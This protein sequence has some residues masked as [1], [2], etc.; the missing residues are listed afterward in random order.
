M[1]RTGANSYLQWDFENPALSYGTPFDTPDWKKFGLQQKITGFSINNTKK[2]LAEM[3][4]IEPTDYAYGKQVGSLSVDFVLS[5][6]WIFGMLFGIPVSNNSVGGVSPAD[7]TYAI[8]TG[9]STIRTATLEMGFDGQ[10]GDVVRTI[11]G[12]LLNS[13]SL[14]ASVDDLVNMTADFQYAREGKP[15]TSFTAS[16]AVD[17]MNFP[18]T[19]AHGIFKWKGNTGDSLDEVTEVQSM[20]IS[21]NQNAQLLYAMNSH[22]AIGAYRQLF[23]ITG[24]FQTSMKDDSFLVNILEQIKQ[25]SGTTN[26]TRVHAQLEL[27]FTNDGTTDGQKSLR[28]TCDDIGIDTHTL[29]GIEP[30]EPVFEDLTWQINSA[31]VVAETATVDDEPIG[32][33]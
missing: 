18:Y 15:G 30:N 2:P 33:T 5:D 25:D 7:H 3:L 11:N 6:P 10:D 12:C 9:E 22:F 8:T 13:L 31:T 24:K 23:E 1:V 27:F 26:D 28:I 16:S 29:S 21:F 20:D 32:T 17:D 14:T 19:F 4:T